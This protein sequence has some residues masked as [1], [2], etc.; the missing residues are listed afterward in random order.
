MSP[1]VFLDK[2]VQPGFFHPIQLLPLFAL[3]LPSEVFHPCAFVYLL[4]FSYKL[5]E[6]RVPAYLLTTL[7]VSF[8]PSLFVAVVE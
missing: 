2:S 5:H 8:Q 6:D 4:I 7:F 3:P 1:T